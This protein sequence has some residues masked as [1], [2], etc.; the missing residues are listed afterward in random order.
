[1]IADMA[2]EV[3]III[4]DD[5]PIVRQ[6]LRQAIEREK[7]FKIVAEA[8][9]GRTAL[10]Q[11]QALAPEIAILDADMPRLDGFGVLRELVRQSLPVKVIFLTIHSE[12]EFFRHA[13]ELGA[14]GYVLKDS[15]VTDVVNS[16]RAVASGHHYTSPAMTSYLMTRRKRAATLTREKPSLEDLT[17]T[18]RRILLLIAEYKT[19]TEI[20]KALF[21]S[22]RTV[23]THRTNICNKLD[24][25]GKHALMKFALSHRDE[26]S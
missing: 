6:G 16:I 12:E 25:H 17:P 18:E 23:E 4:A 5:H 10:E 11:L 24:L 2:P 13:V 26:L 9:D 1:M 3:T 8:A 7:D 15:A 20:A 19:S 21:V 22:P 14:L